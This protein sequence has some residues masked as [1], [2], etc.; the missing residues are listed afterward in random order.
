[1]RLYLPQLSFSA[2]YSTWLAVV[3]V[4]AVMAVVHM[5]ACMAVPPPAWPP[6]LPSRTFVLVLVLVLVLGDSAIRPAGRRARWLLRDGA[7]QRQSAVQRVAKIGIL[8][9][10]RSLGL[11]GLIYN[12]IYFV[13]SMMRSCPWCSCSCHFS[14]GV[15]GGCDIDLDK[16]QRCQRQI[17]TSVY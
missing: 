4:A 16:P 7:V 6:A 1:M 17:S 5:A 13:Q 10:G 3:M 12:T 2:A 8:E 14:C 15:C 11:V 9:R